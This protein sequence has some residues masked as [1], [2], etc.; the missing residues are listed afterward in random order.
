MKNIKVKGFQNSL[1][2]T[3][4]IE[5]VDEYVRYIPSPMI[6][7]DLLS[8]RR[9]KSEEADYIA[10]NI[11]IIVFDNENFLQ[12]FGPG[13]RVHVKG[14]WQSRNFTRDYYDV[15]EQIQN[16]VD[17]YV[18]LFNEF[19]SKKQPKGRIRQPLDW[20][21]L[22]KLSL[23]AGVP[24]DS[25]FKEDGSKEKTEDSQYVYRVDENG[26]VF[27]ETEHVSY[28]VIAHSVTPVEEDMD[29]LLGDVNRIT[30]IGKTTRPPSFDVLGVPFSNFNVQ[31]HLKYFKDQERVAYANIIVWGESAEDVFG[32]VQKTDLVKIVGRIQSRTYTKIEIKRWKTPSGRRKKKEI[33]RPLITREISA[34]KIYKVE[35]VRKK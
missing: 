31:T 22:L 16:A 30:I 24:E 1:E 2:L 3:G 28:E 34:S 32:N 27:K 18:Q 25:M 10:D 29:P 14:E 12:E 23:L 21:K 20:S 5:K 6:G 9:R 35:I 33:E 15:D 11:R 19:P 4:T 8:Y 13:M 26:E 17:M 7:F